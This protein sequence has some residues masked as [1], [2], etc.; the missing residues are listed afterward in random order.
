VQTPTIVTLDEARSELGITDTRDDA[1]LLRAIVGLQDRFAQHCRRLFERVAGAIELID[2]GGTWLFLKRYPVES[3]ASVHVDSAQAF[4]ADTL[5]TAATDYRLNAARGYVAYGTSGEKWPAGVS[6]VRVV[7]TGGYVPAGQTA[8]SGQTAMPEDLRRC[9]FLQ[10][11]FEWRNRLTLG[12]SSVSAQ[13]VS[14][15]LAPAKLLP[16]VEAGLAPYVRYV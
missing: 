11:G 1:S 13:G 9:L 16:E 7:Y 2:G 6:N 5:L 15:N 8:A 3:I 14:V 10:L 4:G 12:A